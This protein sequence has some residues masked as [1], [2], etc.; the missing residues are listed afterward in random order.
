MSNAVDGKGLFELGLAAAQA[1]A[2][3]EPA[4]ADIQDPREPAFAAGVIDGLAAALTQSLGVLRRLVKGASAAAEDLNVEPFQGVIEVMQ[5]AD[6]LNAANLRIALIGEDERR[7]LLIVHDGDPV[8]CHHVL[9]MALPYLTNKTNEADLKGRFGIGLKT[10]R[11]ISTQIGIHS[12][13]YHFSAQGVDIVTEQP[14]VAIESFY[15]PARDT[16]LA[17]DLVKDFNP[18]DLERWFDDWDEENLLF[19]KSV[20]CFA[21]VDLK[22]GERKVREI[23]PGDWSIIEQRTEVRTLIEQ[24]TTS[25]ASGSWTI[26]RATIPTPEG[27]D[28][29]HKATGSTTA[30]SIAL[31]AH[32]HAGGL[33]IGFRTR[34]PV[35]LPFSID[36]QFDPSA[37][38]EALIDNIWNRWLIGKVGEAVTLAARLCF[39]KD[40]VPAWSLVPISTETVG[41]PDDKWPTADFAAAFT[42]TRSQVAQSE[43]LIAGQTAPFSSVAYEGL[44]LREF[45]SADDI[46]LLKPDATPLDASA[47][48]QAGRWRKV[49]HGLAVATEI[50]IA[51]F[52]DG[53][54]ESL[55]VERDID[56]WI[57]AGDRL[58][59]HARPGALFGAPCFL[60]DKSRPIGVAV[61]GST[62]R[63]LVIGDPI[64]AFAA[65]WEL[66]ERLHDRYSE[67]GAGERVKNWLTANASVAVLIEAEDEL[68]AF[69]E[70]H[71][72][73]PLAIGDDEFRSLRDR[74]DL[75][76][77]RKAELIGPKVG[78]ALLLD[79]YVHRGKK[80]VEVKVRP[81]E[82][83][84]PKS[85]D[86]EHPYWAEAA[87]GLP[88]I[89]WLS[90]S[91]EERLR[92]GATRH[93]RKRA[94]G[95]IS[96]GAR[97]FLVLLGAA[98]SP[99]LV[100]TGRR[101]GGTGLR[102][103]AL[104][105]KGADYV[106]AD[107]ASPDLERV[108]SAI[109]SMPKRDR[110]SRSAPLLKAL[111][112]YW[113]DYARHRTA[114]AYRTPISVEH[115]KGEVECD[116]LC[117]LRETPW[118]A[119]GAGDLA[120]PERAVVKGSQ[121]Q[122]LYGAKSLIAGI[123]FE[124]LRGEMPAALKLITD[125]RASDLVAKLEEMRAG[126]GRVDADQTQ[127][128][129]RALA[130]L[131]VPSTGWDPKISDML[132][133]TLRERFGRPPG[134]IFVP[135]TTGNT[136][137][138]RRPVELFSGSD[139]FHSPERFVPGGPSFAA[140]WKALNVARPALDDCILVL[141]E[142]TSRPYSVAAEAVLID[143]YTYLEAVLGKVDRQPREKMRRLPVHTTA[144]W[145]TQRPVYHA[146]DREVRQQLAISRPD[147]NFWLPP[148]DTRAL[149]R[150]CA[151]L[152]LVDID[153]RLTV[154]DDER[155]KAAGADYAQRFQACVDHLSNELAR[156]DP[157]IRDGISVPWTALR[158]MPL[159]VYEAPFAAQARDPALGVRPVE[160]EVQALLQREP[161]QLSICLHAFPLRNQCGRAI[162]SLFPPHARHRIEAEWVASWM[163][164]LE[165]P[166]ERMT[167]ASDEDLNKA[168]ADRAAATVIAPN[169]KIQVTQPASRAGKTAPPRR[170]KEAH[171]GIAS[172]E[173][174]KGNPPTPAP[175]KPPLADTPPT[176]TPFSSPAA[177][178]R[179]TE[180]ST[181]D[182]EQ[183]GWEILQSVLLSSGDKDVTDFRRTHRIGADGA[184][185]WKKFVELKAT[186]QGPQSSIEMSANE[187]ERAREQGLNFI[188]ALVAGLED[189]YRTQV[190]LV[191]DPAH[192]ASIRPVGSVRLV[193]LTD[194]PSLKYMIAEPE[195]ESNSEAMP[196]D[197][198]EEV[199]TT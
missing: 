42:T 195:A 182:L 166:V 73:Q 180:Y 116:W 77:E 173:I 59:M 60:S 146:Q 21:M 144:G 133:S 29:S 86:K 193:G 44:P 41:L 188:L 17:L 174:I 56:W 110:K 179:P 7:Q 142:M 83:Y 14:A 172:V 91:Y 87:N 187:Y 89:T 70:V 119:V 64:S 114:T 37:T 3:D 157:S 85:I 98:V 150:L 135:A 67:G 66:F 11:R 69:A 136:G 152:G 90:P 79:G 108:L 143:V 19:L 49:L 161:L 68:S 115:N 8:T 39:L 48:D 196:P 9:G 158:D 97:K 45:L 58:T 132:T 12:A 1:I 159:A 155:A 50:D 197:L 162:A 31:P 165:A 122:T 183:R 36:A 76:G 109:G 129:Y 30:I 199:A 72:A 20:R 198:S 160:I 103:A 46:R 24:R 107:Y 192:R 175:S 191:F 47:R 54:R 171:G 25:S 81:T 40:P 186:G 26:Y 2:N 111:A 82:A 5:N 139:I 151:Q 117:R 178:P 6:D 147:L 99:R 181:A 61:A 194:V 189:G 94:D 32:D 84:L 28:R 124:D 33:F 121:T 78:A 145:S 4:A 92:T 177:P 164:S 118:I 148:C 141:K 57:L 52:L 185:E 190:M 123:A 128:L 163:A 167:M 138:W 15:D 113:G 63:K 13:P 184:I 88:G 134:L 22:T 35:S 170:L 34:I 125:V 112:R 106:K 137:R 140:L 105:S 71:A 96:R 10:L 23:S 153:P 101:E 169:N 27:I 126:S 100:A 16:L 104:R 75:V 127:Q 156:N 18:S 93:S 74:F 102:L 130:K 131:C 80:R 65:R 149:P 51:L 168:L 95:T 62:A 38:R 43:I 120:V 176:P 55:F 53:F 154:R